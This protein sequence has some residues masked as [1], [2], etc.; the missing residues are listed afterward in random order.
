MPVL[1][2]GVNGQDGVHLVGAYA[3]RGVPVVGT[4]LPGAAESPYLAGC[5]LES[6]DVRDTDAFT[7][8]IERHQPETVVNLAA[9][10]SI[11]RSWSTPELAAEVNGSAVVGLLGA[12]RAFRD[13]HGWAP[14]FVQASTADIFGPPTTL[15][16]TEEAPHAPVSPYGIGKLVAH[17]AVVEA[18]ADEL[19]AVN[20]ILFNHESPIR[21]AH[22]V[23]RKVAR[24]AA[25][26]AL[27]LSESVTLG[28]VGVRRDWGAAADH[29]RALWLMAE[30][31]EPRDYVVATGR[32]WS[33]AEVVELSFAAAGVSDPWAHVMQD[34][35]LVR[36]ADVPDLVGDPSRAARDL[37]WTPTISF[38][39]LIARMVSVELQRLR[40]GVEDDPAYL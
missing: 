25:S 9:L 1:I 6:L 28:T 2:T 16:L 29:V 4:V 10:S 5:P 7:A 18:R 37:G 23:V 40:S 17:D 14:R 8:L 3:A 20:A 22:F 36:P 39:D 33:L 19:F 35:D 31:S 15:P 38:D 11:G 34:P 30:A 12:L 32:S 27:G 24:A 26:I 13:A 21:P